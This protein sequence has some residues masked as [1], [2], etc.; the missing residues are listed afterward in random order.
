MLLSAN[1]DKEEKWMPAPSA[2]ATRLTDDLV[3]VGESFGF[4]ATKEHTVLESS[5]LRVDA[6]WKITSTQ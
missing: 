3:E 6:F 2:L 5:K 4:E 1:E